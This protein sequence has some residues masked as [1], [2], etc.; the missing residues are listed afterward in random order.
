MIGPVSWLG[1]ESA[2]PVFNL[3]P[4]LESNPLPILVGLF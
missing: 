2:D 4:P 1:I 3:L